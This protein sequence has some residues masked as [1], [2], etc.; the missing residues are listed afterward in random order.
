[1]S[2][3]IRIFAMLF[4]GETIQSSINS[5]SNKRRIAQE[6]RAVASKPQVNGANPFSPAK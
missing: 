6:C 5:E 1:M 2:D 3:F 4:G